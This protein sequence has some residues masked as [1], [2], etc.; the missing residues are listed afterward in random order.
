MANR[1]PSAA[2]VILDTIEDINR[3]NR[4]AITTEMHS[5]DW[6]FG[7][8]AI[9]CRLLHALG[10]YQGFAYLTASELPSGELPGVIMDRSEPHD[11]TKNQFP[12][13]SRVVWHTGKLARKVNSRKTKAGTGI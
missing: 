3:T 7:Q 12:D 2:A 5:K 6:R 13:E 8:N 9:A 4:Y 11:P 1:R 10:C